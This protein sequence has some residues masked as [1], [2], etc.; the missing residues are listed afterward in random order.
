[1]KNLEPLSEILH[2]RFSVTL[3]L[4]ATGQNWQSH[5]HHVTL[6]LV[7]WPSTSRLAIVQLCGLCFLALLINFVYFCRWSVWT[8]VR[9]VPVAARS[10]RSHPAGSPAAV[11][12]RTTWR[13]RLRVETFILVRT[14]EST[15]R[16]SSSSSSP[17]QS[18]ADGRPE[19]SRS[20]RLAVVVT[21]LLV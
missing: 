11:C 13:L 9:L 12:Y 6:A 18:A 19:G 4:T 17:L 8:D 16:S 7:N 14:N 15:V 20:R 3:A 10:C 2:S 21:C 5:C 1:M